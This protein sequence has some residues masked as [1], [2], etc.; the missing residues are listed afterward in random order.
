MTGLAAETP[1]LEGGP[2]VTEAELASE[3]RMAPGRLGRVQSFI[4]TVELTEGED[5]IATVAGLR[6]WLAGHGLDVAAGSLSQASVNEARTLR[7]ALRDLIDGHDD[8]T[9]SGATGQAAQTLDVL[10]GRYPMVV[11]FSPD[12]APRLAAASGGFAG[13]LATLLAD[14]A[15][16]MGDGTWSRFKTCHND[17]CRWAFYDGSKNRSGAWCSMASCG[18]RMKG[19]AFRERRRAGRATR[20]GDNAS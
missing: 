8:G 10:A 13:A 11:R 1:G 7:E 6:A 2:Y 14:I 18:N 17:D 5:A 4:N 19:R 16:A 20:P 3:P 9:G 12:G 15:T